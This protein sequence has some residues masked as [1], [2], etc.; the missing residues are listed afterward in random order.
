MR[1][2]GWIAAGGLVST[3]AS[4]ASAAGFPAEVLSA[5]SAG[6]C[7]KI[8]LL[9]PEPW[10]Y[11]VW[12]V[13]SCWSGRPVRVAMQSSVEDLSCSRACAFRII[14]HLMHPINLINQCLSLSR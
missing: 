12:V 2:S 10:P 3:H 9:V 4:Q 1:P 5:V 6:A 14:H 13:V 8:S 11:Q 7:V